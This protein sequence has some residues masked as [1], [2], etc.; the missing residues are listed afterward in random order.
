MFK[1]NILRR[2]LLLLVF[3]IYLAGCSMHDHSGLPY[4]AKLGVRVPALSNGYTGAFFVEPFVPK[5][6][7]MERMQERCKEYGGLDSSSLK[8]TYEFPITGEK[9]IE[10]KCVNASISENS[11]ERKIV[12]IPQG[13]PKPTKDKQ[14]DF[15]AAKVKCVELGFSVATEK[16]RECV[17]RLSE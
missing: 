12:E 3:Q 9:I 15:E 11:Q 6:E 7:I 13:I 14:K 8:T 10:Y 5:S 17:L 2:L 1:F 4:H 16:Y